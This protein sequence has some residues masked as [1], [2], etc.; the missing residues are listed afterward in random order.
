MP[1]FTQLASFCD[2]GAYLIS[3]I[4]Q[5][6]SVITSRKLLTQLDNPPSRP[7]ISRCR[8]KYAAR[9]IVNDPSTLLLLPR[10]CWQPRCTTNESREGTGRMEWPV[11]SFMVLRAIHNWLKHDSRQWSEN[12]QF[13]L[14]SNLQESPPIGGPTALWADKFYSVRIYYNE[15][16]LKWTLVV[17]R[18]H[19]IENWIL[20]E[21]IFF[22]HANF[23]II[24]VPLI[25][26]HW[27]SPWES[28]TVKRSRRIGFGNFA[29]ES[30]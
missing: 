20:A 12:K 21:G 19:W 13:S 26:W 23:R 2:G 17:P 7:L 25:S 18:F 3:F 9:T 14:R 29:V 28:S 22:A 30:L 27:S 15:G 1:L 5:V 24:G 6:L 10:R 16:D 8:Q 11:T 4:R